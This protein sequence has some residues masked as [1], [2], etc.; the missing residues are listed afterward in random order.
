M[1]LVTYAVGRGSRVGAVVDDR[2]VDLT[3][4]GVAVSMLDLIRAG[5]SGLAK[6]KRAV[7][8]ANGKGKR[9][10]DVRL[11]API[12][13][14]GKVLCSGINY[15]SHADENPNA[16]MPAYPHFFAKVSTAIAGPEDEIRLP[17]LTKQMDYEV[18][19]SVVIGRRLS[20]PRE[21]EVMPAIFGY[22]L[23]NDVSARDV[24]FADNQI[25]TGKN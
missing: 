5:R 12:E 8:E 4:A 25:T 18:E 3:A 11:L 17:A 9:L 16:K 14:P 21:D 2:V 20:Q 19:F 13:R 24:Q 22:T 15:K 10:A 7:K 6:A 23:L 1:K